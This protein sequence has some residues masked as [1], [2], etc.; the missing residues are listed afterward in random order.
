MRD[1]GASGNSSTV[2]MDYPAASLELVAEG[3]AS[4][5]RRHAT[6]KEPF[7]VEWIESLPAGDVLFDIG[8]NVGAYSLIAAARPQGPLRV[9][10][11]E[12]AFANYALLCR[13]IVANDAAAHVTPL[14]VTLGAAT[15]LGAFAY[16]DLAGGAASHAGI[17]GTDD[18]VYRQP[19]LV[20]ALDELIEQFGLPFPNHVKLDVDGAESAVLQGARHA[21]GR[22]ELQSVLV[23]LGS[24]DAEIEEALAAAGLRHAQGFRTGTDETVKYALFARP[25]ES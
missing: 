20:Y 14:P 5:M 6:R 18:S 23:E 3:K 17:A 16:R 12:P 24:D 2:P 4:A 21:L 15:T 9:V 22:Q 19:M 10:A 13:N 8:A 7:T 1:S 25:I 11:F